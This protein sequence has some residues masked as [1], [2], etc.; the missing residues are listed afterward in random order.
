[1]VICPETNAPLG[2]D[3]EQ[4]LSFK[5]VSLV[6]ERKREKQEAI[7]VSMN[8][9][10]KEVLRRMTVNL[11][12]GTSAVLRRLILYVLHRIFTEHSLT[13]EILLRHYQG[14]HTNAASPG[15]F[16][17]DKKTYKTTVRLPGKN[18]QQLNILAG[19][20]LYL[21]GKLVSIFIELFIAGVIAEGEIWKSGNSECEIVS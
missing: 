6:Q 17:N 9:S 18:Y 1:M 2:K 10:Q 20:G 21:P 16:W 8:D 12:I 14:L 7:S 11:G 3:I 4:G 19:Q 15:G 13:L 5:E